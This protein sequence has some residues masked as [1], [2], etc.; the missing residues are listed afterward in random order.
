MAPGAPRRLGRANFEKSEI[1]NKIW[2]YSKFRQLQPLTCSAGAPLAQGSLFNFAISTDI[3]LANLEKVGG[4]F[5]RMTSKEA[6]TAY[7][8]VQD[9][10]AKFLDALAERGY[11]YKNGKVTAAVP[12]EKEKA[13]EAVDSEDGVRYS[14]SN[15]IDLSDDTELLQMIGEKTGS[16]K[17]KIIQ[18]YVFESLSGKIKLSDGIIATVDNRDAK[19]ISALHSDSK[20]IAEVSRIREIVETAIPVAYEDST[21]NE[22]FSSFRYYQAFVKYGNETFPIY[23]NV[24]LT[25]NNTGYRIYD[26]TEK[27]RDTAHLL[28]GVGRLP[29][30]SITLGNGILYNRISQKEESVNPESEIF[31]FSRTP[32]TETEAFKRWFGDSKVVNEDGTPKVLYHQTA[33]E[34]WKF[35]TENPVAGKNDSE[36]PN[37]IFLKENDHDIGIGGNRQM[38]LYAKMEK[39]LHFANRA[40]ARAWYVKHIPEYAALQKE[41]DEKTA[42]FNKK[43]AEL[44]QQWFDANKR[45]DDTALKKI[46]AQEDELIKSFEPV[47]AEYSQKLR[48]ILNDYFIGGKSGYDGIILDY[49][50]HRY[51]DGK[52]ENVHTYIVF[53]NTQVKS[54]TDNIGTFD[55]SNPDIRFSRAENNSARQDSRDNAEEKGYHGVRTKKGIADLLD[56]IIETELVYD[57]GKYEEWRGVVRGKGKIVD[58]MLEGLKTAKNKQVL[59]EQIADLLIDQTVMEEVWSQNK[60]DDAAVERAQNIVSMMNKY[61]HRIKF[62]AGKKICKKVLTNRFPYDIIPSLSEDSRFR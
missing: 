13:A 62:D 22:K 20:G 42:D 56:T 18:Q 49:D 28:K 47:E 3:F 29:D 27:I 10:K 24:G 57:D 23:V 30:G 38:A 25:E 36:T 40:E 17:H 54:A 61:R 35:S 52:R 37:G 6:R 19:H 55:S 4:W 9:I 31:L 60:P 59:A 5:K 21:D 8:Q 12:D 32:Q 44:E 7:K 16:A 43:S 58:Q 2:F 15:P 48:N 39:P 46:E 50:G 14:R 51:V 33:A 1:K 41:F 34:F 11:Q 53:K 26:L 45:D